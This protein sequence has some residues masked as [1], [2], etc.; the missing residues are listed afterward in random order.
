MKK[1]IEQLRDLNMQLSLDANNLASAL[2]GESKTQGDW[3]EFRLEMI[4]E[5]A[6]L[7]RRI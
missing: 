3:G 6:I 1:E 2:K 4:L 5:K 7:E